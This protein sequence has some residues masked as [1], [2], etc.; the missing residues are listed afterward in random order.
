MDSINQCDVDVRRDLYGGVVLT[1]CTPSTQY[2][3]ASHAYRYP[4]ETCTALW[5]NTR[6]LPAAFPPPPPA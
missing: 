1:G 6:R 5:D 4:S 3:D 2:H